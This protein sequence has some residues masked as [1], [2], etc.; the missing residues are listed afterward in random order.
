MS[1]GCNVTKTAVVQEVGLRDGLQS[2]PEI[3]PTE[4]KKA[5]INSAYDAGV[6]HIEVASFVPARLLP[7]MADAE[8]IVAHARTLPGLIVTALVPNM[9]G[10]ENALKAGA[11]RIVVP[12]SV[13]E[14]HSLANVRRTPVEMIDEFRRIRALRDS[15]PAWSRTKLIAG[16]STVFGCPFQG[17]V[18]ERDVLRIALHAIEAGADVIA[19][20]DTTGH[21]TPLHVGRLL[22]I[23]LAAA[24]TKVTSLHLHDTRGLALANTLVALE[25]GIREFDASLAG[26]GGCPNAPGATG[27][28]ATEDLVYMLHCM[29][30]DTG[31]D[32][33]KLIEG[34]AVLR[35]AIPDVPL[36]G[37]IGRDGILD[38]SVP[39][40][41]SARGEQ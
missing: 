14:K 23:L 2:I 30:F 25:H 16:L 19:L 28:V 36:H 11:H 40:E 12:I 5:W 17:Y 7:Q 8:S 26:L 29:G 41:L 21:A 24:G 18:P 20:G 39:Q 1:R 15:D 35:Q 3:M 33:H 32:L 31:I 6:R 34:R 4:A 9:K 13:S 27:N 38:G 37:S 22:E 10:A